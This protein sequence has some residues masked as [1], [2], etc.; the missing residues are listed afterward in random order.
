M[1]LVTRPLLG[2]DAMADAE[3]L[4]GLLVDSVYAVSAAK[5]EERREVALEAADRIEDI[6]Y[7]VAYNALGMLG[8]TARGLVEELRVEECVEYLSSSVVCM[9]NREE[10]IAALISAW[11]SSKEA[12]WLIDMLSEE[13]GRRLYGLEAVIAGGKGLMELREFDPGLEVAGPG[14]EARHNGEGRRPG[15]SVVAEIKR[16][17]ELALRP[18]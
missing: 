8:A 1:S 10:A 14:L 18:V 5:S 15:E 9:V 3:R 17:I 2:R 12:Y 4:A 7:E 11:V 6:F 16:T 13:K